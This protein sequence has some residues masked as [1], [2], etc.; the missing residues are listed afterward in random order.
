MLLGAV[1]FV[2]LVACVNV[3]NLLLARAAARGGSSLCGQ[4]WERVSPHHSAIADREHSARFARRG[5]AGLL[6]AYW[7]LE[8]MRSLLP[9]SLPRHNTISIDGRVL[10]FTLL[11]SGLTVMV[12]GLLPAFQTARDSVREA[13]N[14]GGRGGAAGRWRSRLRDALVVI[15]MA[16]ALVLLVGAGLM[17]RSFA[18]FQQVDTGF[19]ATNVLT[20]RIPL[21]GGEVPHSKARM[22]RRPP[23]PLLQSIAGAG[24]GIARRRVR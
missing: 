22:R 7:G 9:A 4:H 12:F 10:G 23:A 1:A 5:G 3:A 18:R 8:L 14:E 20:M 6:L 11:A 16:L 19:S 17:L 21:R 13:L 24:Q 15:E 2:L